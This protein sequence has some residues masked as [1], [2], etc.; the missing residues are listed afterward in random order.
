MMMMMAMMLFILVAN[1]FM[2]MMLLVSVLMVFTMSAD[3]KARRHQPSPT[4]LVDGR[5]R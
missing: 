1:A 5:R 3:C 4:L 2:Q